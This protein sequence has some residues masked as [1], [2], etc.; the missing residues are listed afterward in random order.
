L[1]PAQTIGVLALGALLLAAI[2]APYTGWWRE[3]KYAQMPLEALKNE[4]ATRGG[5]PIFLYYLGYRLNEKGQY[6]EAAEAL[7]P[8]VKMEPTSTRLRDAWAQAQLATGNAGPAFSQL[9]Q[10]TTIRPNDPRSHLLLGKLHVTLGADTLAEPELKEA[11]RLDARL[12]DAWALLG[13]VQHRGAREPEAIASFRKALEREPDRAAAHATLGRLLTTRDPKAAEE[14]FRRAVEIEPENPVFRHERADFFHQF[15]RYEEAE[16]EAREALRHDPNDARANLVLGRCLMER[17]ALSEAR[18][19]LERTAA[20]EP[21]DPL[22]AQALQRLFDKLDDRT[23]A[24]EW[25]KKYGERRAVAEEGRRLRD[26]LLKEPR[27]RDLHRQM[28]HYKARI[29]KVEEC[30]HHLA[31]ALTAPLDSPT[32]LTAAVKE[33]R[34]AGKTAEAD[35]LERQMLSPAESVPKP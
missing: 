7:E 35:A 20:L 27:N 21:F 4:Q 12:A 16:K 15:G 25:A 8:A 11:L 6:R 23:K 34:D 31:I 29:G 2:A 18:E 14:A 33:L 13:D 1:S 22:P 26:A 28:G 5:D 19:P 10:F 3:T 30:V 9:K 17:N 32:V 24:A